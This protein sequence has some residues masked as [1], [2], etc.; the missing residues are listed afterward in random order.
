MPPKDKPEQDERSNVLSFCQFSITPTL[1]MK[2]EDIQREVLE[3]ALDRTT[4]EYTLAVA[5]LVLAP[6]EMQSR[7]IGLFT[8]T[9][10]K[11]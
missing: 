1:K 7:I 2:R 11:R 5:L 6:S 4:T 3:H 9:A 8:E 10:G